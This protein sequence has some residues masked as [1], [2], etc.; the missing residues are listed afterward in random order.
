ML[1]IPKKEERLAQLAEMLRSSGAPT[2]EII[3]E[4]ISAACPR[5]QSL[6]QSGAAAANL[7]RLAGSSAWTDLA[8]ALLALELPGWKMRRAIYE[9]GAWFCSLSK[10]PEMPVELDDTVDAHHG[11]LSLAILIA[12]VEALRANAVSIS[13]PRLV[14][15]IAATQGLAACCDNFA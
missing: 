9:D 6:N 4:V 8:I 10:H 12:F 2:S 3:A 1:F 13:T 14:P 11:S 7:L 15:R 5:L